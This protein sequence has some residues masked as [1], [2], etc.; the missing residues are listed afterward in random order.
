MFCRKHTTIRMAIHVGN[1]AE[2]WFVKTA[3]FHRR[4]KFSLQ[5]VT[6]APHKST[7][8]EYFWVISARKKIILLNIERTLL[9]RDYY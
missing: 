2:L 3:V 4:F 9:I 5:T 7:F 8:P 1:D 6:K